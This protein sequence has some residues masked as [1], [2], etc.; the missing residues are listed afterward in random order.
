MGKRFV[1]YCITY[2]MLT[3]YRSGVSC[4]LAMQQVVLGRCFDRLNDLRRRDGISCVCG[5]AA[6]AGPKGRTPVVFAHN[7]TVY[8]FIPVFESGQFNLLLFLPVSVC[9]EFSVS[10][11]WMFADFKDRGE[12]TLEDGGLQAIRGLEQLPEK[13]SENFIAATTIISL[14]CVFFRLGTVLDQTLV[15]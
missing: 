3:C 2:A 9:S 13:V 15:F 4:A 12:R 10:L 5:L 8:F 1:F 6:F 7:N 11:Q 14:D